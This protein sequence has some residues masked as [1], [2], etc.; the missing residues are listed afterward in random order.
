M[1]LVIKKCLPYSTIRRVRHRGKTPEKNKVFHHG[2][3]LLVILSSFSC[4]CLPQKRG[5][6]PLLGEVLHSNGRVST[7]EKDAESQKILI[8]FPIMV[9]WKNTLFHGKPA[10]TYP[11]RLVHAMYY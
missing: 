8:A 4:A 9:F 5:V 7:D 2:F 10:C 3:R 6:S 11:I 1:N